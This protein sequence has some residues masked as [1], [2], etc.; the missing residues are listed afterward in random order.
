MRTNKA[1]E[2]LA[3]LKAERAKA[4]ALPQAS[5]QE[6]RAKWTEVNRLTV[7]IAEANGGV[8]AKM[9]KY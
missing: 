2:T 7:A 1:N 6:Y 3:R 4:L 8:D 9:R 5:E